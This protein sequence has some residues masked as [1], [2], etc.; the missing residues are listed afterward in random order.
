MVNHPLSKKEEIWL[1]ICICIHTNKYFKK[2][3]KQEKLL[4]VGMDKIEKK[5][6]NRCQVFVSYFEYLLM[7]TIN[8]LPQETK[9]SFKI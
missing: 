3:I 9:L 7:F 6:R 8:I 1:N 4:S 2:T 5:G